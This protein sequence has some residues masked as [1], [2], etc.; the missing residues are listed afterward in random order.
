MFPPRKERGYIQAKRDVDVAQ[1]IYEMLSAVWKKQS[2]WSNAP[3]EVQIVD[4]SYI[5]R[6]AIAPVKT[7]ILLGSVIWV[8]S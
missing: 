6:K 7:F 8:L 3:N 1:D 5:A 4:V 2:S